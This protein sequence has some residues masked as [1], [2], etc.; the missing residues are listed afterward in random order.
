MR[1]DDTETDPRADRTACRAIGIRSMVI[2]PLMHRTE[3]IGALKA[4][5]AR[6]NAFN[7][8][9]AYTLQLIAGFTSAALMLAREF[10]D[11]QASEERYR[12]LFERNVAGVFRTTRDGRILDCNDALVEYLG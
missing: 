9:D 2:A 5:A 8:L 4:F 12:M 6:E 3:A 1:C 7:D 11:R 10:R